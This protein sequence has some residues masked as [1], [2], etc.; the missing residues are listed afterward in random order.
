MTNNEIR[1]M[2]ALEKVLQRADE[3]ITRSQMV[4]GHPYP[5]SAV[6]QKLN[7]LLTSLDDAKRLR[8]ELGNR[9]DWPMPKAVK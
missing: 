1:Y 7:R 4:E 3:A 2:E 6:P 9:L 5:L 8:Q